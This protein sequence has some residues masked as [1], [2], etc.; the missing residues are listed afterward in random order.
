M[1]STIPRDHLEQAMTP[2]LYPGAID[3]F[4]DPTASDRLDSPPH[5]TLHA[6]KHDA[7]EKIETEL[8]VA[9]KTIDDTVTPTATP[10]S[11]AIFLDMVANILKSIKGVA[12]WYTVAAA[13]IATIWAKFNATTGH[14]H[15]AAAD[16]GPKLDHGNSLTGLGDDDHP[17]YALD[18]D[19]ATHKSASPIDHPNSS[20]ILGGW[21]PTGETWTYASADPPT[22]TFT[23]SGD[24]TSKYSPGMRIKL[25][26][27]TIK[28]FIITVVT[29]SAPD[30]TITI[31][32]GT[33]YTLADAAITDPYY[34]IQKAPQ[35]FPL[36]PTKWQVRVTD[37]LIQSQASPAA[38]TWYNLGSINIVI[39]IGCWNVSYQV[40]LSP[41]RS[42]AGA[43]VQRSTLS[44]SPTSQSDLDFSAYVYHSSGT[45]ISHT[46]GRQKVL[47]LGS[48]T[49]Y[50]LIAMGDGVGLSA[51]R[52]AGSVSTTIITAVCAY[53]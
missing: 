35:G 43:M 33:D 42:T 23:I 28:Y 12:N 45:D 2:S 48:K 46:I 47:T 29:Y 51:I 7:I 37:S 18:T 5:A 30:T 8:G 6:D 10:D 16:D 49:T 4:T 40:C 31:Y 38:D 32:G 50:Y 24:K 53:V 52:F 3:S 21:I 19:L 26:Q 44:T 20:D 13:S 14:A 15:T 39:P 36:A 41:Q 25:T 17:Q 9:P 34:S 27:T 1:D 11:V 22:F